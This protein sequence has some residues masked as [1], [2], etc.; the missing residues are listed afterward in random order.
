MKRLFF[1]FFLFFSIK[2]FSQEVS[3]KELLTY[4][5]KF[6]KKTIEIKGEV[7]GEPILGKEGSWINISDEGFSLGVFIGNKNFFKKI[8]YWG[9]YKTKGDVIKLKGTF[10][11]NCPL[12]FE[13]DF[14]LK[15]LKVVKNGFRKK[16]KISPFKVK[17][18]MVSF[19]ICL[20]AVLT[21]L[22]KA[23]YE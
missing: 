7:I 9:S 15:D 8:T 2:L 17:L 19:I 3:L 18:A 13:Q 23:K 5:D 16:E 10:F 1:I 12:H 14:H 22:I 20:V 21:Y 6:D 11:K 4:P